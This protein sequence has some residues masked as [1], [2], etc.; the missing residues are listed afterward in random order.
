M[1]GISNQNFLNFIEEKTNDLIKKKIVG[2]L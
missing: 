2:V 1:A